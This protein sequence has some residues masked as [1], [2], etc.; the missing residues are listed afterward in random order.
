MSAVS[1]SFECCSRPPRVERSARLSS[2][3]QHYNARRVL[4]LTHRLSR[5]LA[6]VGVTARPPH[7]SILFPRTQREARRPQPRYG[8]PSCPLPTST[9]TRLRA[10]NSCTWRSSCWTRCTSTCG[11]APAEQRHRCSRR[12]ADGRTDAKAYIRCPVFKCGAEFH[13]EAVA[14]GRSAALFAVVARSARRI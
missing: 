2:T 9:R 11:I 8:S 13:A 6:G 14:R 5:V 10:R 4:D 3:L 1:I 12:E 7:L